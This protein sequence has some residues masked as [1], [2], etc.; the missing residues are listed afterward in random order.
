MV[1]ATSTAVCAALVA[2]ASDAAAQP[3]A[4]ERI[5]LQGGYIGEARPEPAPHLD[6]VWIGA[7][8]QLSV[9]WL[10]PDATL[11]IDYQLTAALHSFNSLSEIA[12]LLTLASAIDLSRRT[13]LLLTAEG[14]QSTY[15]N[16][17][18]SRPAGAAP[19]ALYPSAGN[20]V[21]TGRV[22]EVISHDL[23]P[24]VRLEQDATL[25]VFTT[26]APSPPLDTFFA[27]LGGLVERT[28]RRDALGAELRSGYV[29]IKAFPPVPDQQFV[30]LTAAPRWR[31]DWTT[32][33]S[34]ALSGGATAV[35]SPDAG[36]APRAAPFGRASVLY[37]ALPTTAEL[38]Y[39]VG[40]FPSV[41]TGLLAET[42]Q[43]TL[44][45]TVPISEHHRVFFGGSVGYQHASLIDLRNL[46][47]DLTYD[48]FLSDVGVTWQVSPLMQVFGR[49]Q[50]I[51]QVGDANAVGLN[52]SL[53][54]DFFIVGV[55]LSS[56]PSPIE[57]VQTR[58]PQRVDQTDA[59]RAAPAA[60]RDP[61]APAPA[62]ADAP[63]PEG[64]GP[65]RWIHTTPALPP[66]PV[67]EPD[68]D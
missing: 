23:T 36:T 7:V 61:R 52:P 6:D 43:V 46:G 2:F 24:A 67:S 48:S 64:P 58:L 35:L 51:A 57:A 45:G 12:N 63:P 50:F 19:V 30:T 62:D 44:Q 55:Q 32:T 31:H 65:T 13:R 15:S 60:R 22:S 26:L 4:V 37:N 16:Y 41:L 29:N 33:V 42:N 25:G 5:R 34:S 38:S 59:P 68:A 56:R 21:I 14:A 3:I 18:I 49:Y 10:T 66:Q 9:F 20:R 1:R 17:L 53:L 11:S 8:P 39:Q 28:W 40:V 47:N 54:R 27:D